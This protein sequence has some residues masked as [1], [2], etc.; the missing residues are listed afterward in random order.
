MSNYP[1]NLI[2]FLQY[3]S[4]NLR[5]N[6]ACKRF[7]ESIPFYSLDKR[8][9]NPKSPLN[10]WAFIRVKNEA[11]TLKASLYS[12]LPAISRG[13]IGYNDCT[14]GSEEII[15]EFC[16]KFPRFLPLKYPHKI[17]LENPASSQ[18][19]LHNYYNFVLDAIPKDEWFIKIDCDH[20]YDAKMLFKTF[21]LPRTR[22]DCVIYPRVNFIVKNRRIYIQNNGKN[23]FIFGNDQLLLCNNN[24]S[25]VPRK[26]S[27]SAQWLDV[28][29][30]AQNLYSEIMI[31]PKNLRYFHAPL[32]QWHF[33][34]VKV[35]RTEF[36]KY[37]DLI[38]LEDF[39][40]QNAHLL[41]T[42]IPPNYLQKEVIFEI[43]NLFD[44]ENSNLEGK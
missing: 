40:S 33:P 22:K 26:T 11:P 30:T 5:G 34:A 44:L 27:K 42:K 24:I 18:N 19:M 3:E 12:I 7:A 28:D 16:K 37:L 32:M 10:P 15:L 23:G 39:I 35:R 1:Q 13:V 31:V 8:S 17:E 43:Y 2:N 4:Q 20:I 25:F 9:K 21:Y 14:D 6:S 38:N 41:G 29:S 36:I